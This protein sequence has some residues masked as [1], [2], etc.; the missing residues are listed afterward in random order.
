MELF[1]KIVKWGG[2]P[3]GWFFQGVGIYYT[4]KD[5]VATGLPAWAWYL[6][7]TVM[8]SASFI[9]IIVGFS[10]ENKTLK[11]T[12]KTGSDI[13]LMEWRQEY[14]KPQ[15]SKVTNIPQTLNQMWK[16]VA[17]VME[18]KK[19]KHVPEEELLSMIVNL[20]QVSQDDPM[21]NANNYATED[22]I[23]KLTK[24]LGT[25]MGLKKSDAKLEAE[26]R[27]R[28]AEEMDSCKIGLQLDKSNEYTELIKE[29][30]EDRVPITKT[31]V[32]HVIDDFIENLH[33]L[34]SIRLLIFY[35]GIEKNKKLSIFPRNI[36]NMLK[37][38][39]E[40]TDK[41]MRSLL[42]RVNDTLEEYSIGK[43]MNE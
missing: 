34:Y 29:L 2:I 25:R 10:K 8:L 38:M 30:N 16:V 23:K 22:K 4:T 32:D 31:K 9:S 40:V 41:A 3:V 20:L 11:A 42:R 36:I 43:D 37:H 15:S 1:K 21:L 27:K 33:A 12:L 13:K 6:I 26:W 17:N 28:T 18:E 5:I 19:G 14:R 24:H 39:E 35:S 7:G